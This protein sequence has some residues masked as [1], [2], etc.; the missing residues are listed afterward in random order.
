M[1]NDDQVWVDLDTPTFQRAIRKL[2]KPELKKVV[3]TLEKLELLTWSDVFQDHGLKWEQVK[4]QAGTYTIRLSKSY[5][6][7]VEREGRFMVFQAIFLDHD[8]AYGK[9]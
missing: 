4:G 2:D 8:G 3:K 1:T 5:R 7:V 6:A 9:K